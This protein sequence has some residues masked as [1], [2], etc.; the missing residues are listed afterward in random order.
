MHFG[1]VGV[2]SEVVDIFLVD[3]LSMLDAR[4]GINPVLVSGFVDA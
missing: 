1:R 4:R 3:P 2:S